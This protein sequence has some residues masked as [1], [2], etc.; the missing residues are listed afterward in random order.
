[1]A[2]VTVPASTVSEGPVD[3]AGCE[4]VTVALPMTVV[5]WTYWWR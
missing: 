3:A 1:M 4:S 2:W 5:S